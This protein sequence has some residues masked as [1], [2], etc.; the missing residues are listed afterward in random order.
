MDA[1]EI[2][3]RLRELRD[4]ARISQKAASEVAGVSLT[5]Y[6]LWENG[7]VLGVE[8]AAKLAEYYGVTLDYIY[9]GSEKRIAEH[10]DDIL[11]EASKRLSDKDRAVVLELVL[12]LTLGGKSGSAQVYR[13]SNHGDE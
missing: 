1:K 5:G 9:L 2:G 3:G 4:I 10:C 8:G 6:N 7:K 12:T 11:C 13:R